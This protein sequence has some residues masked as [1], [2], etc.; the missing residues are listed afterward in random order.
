M[1]SAPNHNIRMISDRKKKKICIVK[2]FHNFNICCIFNKIKGSL[3]GEK[4]QKKKEK[5]RIGIQLFNI[6]II[7]N[8]L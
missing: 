8:N 5:K 1:S 2:T 3:G 6:S 7:I 4:M